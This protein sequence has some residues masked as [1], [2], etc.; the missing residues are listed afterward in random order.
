MGI[1]PFL[2][3][4]GIFLN[5]CLRVTLFVTV[6][7]K[8]SYF[9]ANSSDY[10]ILALFNLLMIVI[11][12]LIANENNVFGELIKSIKKKTKLLRSI[13]SFDKMQSNLFIE[14]IILFRLFYCPSYS[15][16]GLPGH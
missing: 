8:L 5:T 14:K 7:T 12:S 1:L 9:Y 15:Q 13:Y 6:K 10:M 11:L 3:I 2:T 4:S 16:L